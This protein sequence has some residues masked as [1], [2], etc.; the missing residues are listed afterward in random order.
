MGPL[1]S[2]LTQVRG[3]SRSGVPPPNRLRA[4]LF[5]SPVFPLFF[6]CVY[7]LYRAV[8]H[9]AQNVLLLLASWFFYAWWD[10]RFLGLILV[11]TVIDF[12]SAQQLVR[13]GGRR[14]VV[15]SVVTNLAILG[16]FKYLGWLVD[17]ASLFLM[18]W[19]LSESR[20]VLE[21]LLPVGLSFYTFQSMA[22]TI[23]VHRGDVKPTSRF[24]DFALFVSFFPQ[25]VAGPIERASALLPQLESPRKVTARQTAEGAWLI[26]WGY[27]KK[28]FV[29][30]NLGILVEEA[31]G[32]EASGIGVLIGMYA[33]TW[34]IYC[35]FSGYTDIAR[36]VAKLLGVELSINFRL[37]FF[38]ASPAE[39]WRRWH[40]SLSQWLR[41]YLY[42]S[43]GG[44][45]GSKLRTQINLALTMLLGGLWH[46][47]NWTFLAW[48]AYHGL[49]LAI[50][51]QFPRRTLSWP[52]R[53]LAIGATFHFTVLGFTIFR[54]ESM[55]HLVE[56]L[57]QMVRFTY[58]PDDL[59]ALIQLVTLI[60]VPLGIQLAMFLRGDD[61]DLLWKLPRPI[62]AGLVV[63]F[64]SAIAVLGSTYGQSFLYFQF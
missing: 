16:A 32:G 46:G 57:G 60:S 3:L 8:P 26:L 61:L 14:W 5:S 7:A 20:T 44:N 49:A 55:T 6:A 11:S 28:L 51:R 30:D 41:D 63:L 37:P 40:I 4:V 47:A 31:F 1:R 53:A 59:Y 10:W 18:Y 19:G 22:Y 21:I 45:R 12:V 36:G 39:I 43:L 2:P 27:F 34:Q 29:A 54:A 25:L 33:F 42:I 9:R 62:Q 38:A 35:D 48:G 23:D 13:G 58:R 56:L 15:L 50:Q 64:F 52:A 17:E 24:L